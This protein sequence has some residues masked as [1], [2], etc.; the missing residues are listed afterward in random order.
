MAELGAG[1]RLTAAA[2]HRAT[3]EVVDLP[4]RHVDILPTV[5]DALDLTTEKH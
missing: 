1:M 5:L 4:V 2:R 3:G